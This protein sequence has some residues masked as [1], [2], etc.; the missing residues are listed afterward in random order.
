MHN[1]VYKMHWRVSEYFHYTSETSYKQTAFQMCT[2]YCVCAGKLNVSDEE[3]ES[4]LAEGKGPINFTVFL[5]LF[6]EKLS[7]M[8][9]KLSRV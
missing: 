3:L 1:Q 8:T 5:S 2:E 9:T 4:M 7:G 6:G